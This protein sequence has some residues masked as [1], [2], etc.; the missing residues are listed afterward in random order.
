MLR[1]QRIQREKARLAKRP[2][3][4]AKK[5]GQLDSRRRRGLAHR[6]VELRRGHRA[7]SLDRGEPRDLVFEPVQEQLKAPGQVGTHGVPEHRRRRPR[8][9]DGGV[10]NLLILVRRAHSAQRRVRKRRR[11]RGY[12]GRDDGHERPARAQSLGGHLVVLVIRG[13]E[14]LRREGVDVWRGGFNSVGFK[15]QPRQRQRLDPQRA[16]PLGHTAREHLGE[17]GDHE[18]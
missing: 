16:A 9:R 11:V 13:G 5:T 10:L 7:D 1:Y 17:R 14:D 18:P 12:R 6:R 3:R 15:N 2:V 8:A 4:L